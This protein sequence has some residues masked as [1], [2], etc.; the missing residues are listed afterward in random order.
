MKAMM[1][2]KTKTKTTKIATR[3]KLSRS[4]I[5]TRKAQIGFVLIFAVIGTILIIVSKAA[6]PVIDVEVGAGNPN[7]GAVIVTDSTVSGGSYGEFHSSSITPP[8][9]PATTQPNATNTGPDISQC[10]GGL[11][12]VNG[13]Q[14]VSSSISCVDIHGFVTV[15]GSNISIAN[16]V[17]R[18]GTTCPSTTYCG[19]IKF[20]SGSGNTLTRVEIVPSKPSVDFDGIWGSGYTANGVNIHGT[21]D[22]MKLSS[23]TIENSWIHD[24]TLFPDDPVQDARGC[25]GGSPCA[26]HNDDIQVD[27]TSVNALVQHNNLV[28]V[29]KQNSSMQIGQDQGLISG[30]TV[31]DNWMDG[32][33]CTFNVAGSLNSDGKTYNKTGSGYK[34]P[35]TI[36]A[37]NNHFSSTNT[38]CPVIIG[39]SVKLNG[40]VGTFINGNPV[41]VLQKFN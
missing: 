23:A 20:N 36:N 15:N 38:G 27:G 7:G 37:S 33:N 11:K 16:S 24:L 28:S 8:T 13:D 31:T 26:S 29:P 4:G 34:Y 2:T 41:H 17:I 3:I 40:N 10:P 32:G 21:V 30:L 25:S 14:N 6:T 19:L 39:T 22:G 1:K 9:P 12:L 18:G 35:L 5:K